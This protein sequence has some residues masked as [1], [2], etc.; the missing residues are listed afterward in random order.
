MINSNKKRLAYSTEETED[1][2]IISINHKYFVFPK[3]DKDK[4]TD[5]HYDTLWDLT[6]KHG[7]LINPVYA[8]IEDGAVVVDD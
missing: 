4:I 3:K 6:I 8:E 7:E 1:H 5:Q 2:F